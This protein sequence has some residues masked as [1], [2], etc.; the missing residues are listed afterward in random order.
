MNYTFTKYFMN[1]TF[2]KKKKS[3]VSVYCCHIL[4]SSHYVIGS[5]FIENTHTVDQI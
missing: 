5:I 4:F 3:M 1:P 2:L